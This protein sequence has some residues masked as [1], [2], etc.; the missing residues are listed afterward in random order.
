[1]QGTKAE[2]GLEWG[3]ERLRGVSIQHGASAVQAAR[4]GIVRTLVAAAAEPVVGDD[5]GAV[6]GLARTD[7]DGLV[8]AVA[9]ARAASG[10]KCNWMLTSLRDAEQLQLVCMY[11]INS[12]GTCVDGTAGGRRRQR[13][14]WTA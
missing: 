2:L 14:R 5:L 4:D 9:D 6:A 12:G 13:V 3:I 1:V 11:G 10:A 8:A 7:G